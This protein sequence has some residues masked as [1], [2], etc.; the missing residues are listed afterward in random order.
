MS[1]FNDSEKNFERLREQAEELILQQDDFTPR[2]PIDII[3][4]INELRIHQIELE[5]QNEELKRAQEEI[6]ALHQEYQD[7]YEFA[8]VGYITLNSKGIITRINLTASRLLRS[9][10]QLIP[11]QPFTGFICPGW[12]DFFLSSPQKMRQDRTKAKHCSAP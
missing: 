3:E 7:L 6:S 12:E 8:P 4:L 9:L 10:R 2:D 1:N 5:I 11:H